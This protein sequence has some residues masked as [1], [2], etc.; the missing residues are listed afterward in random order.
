[1]AHKRS[2]KKTPFGKRTAPHKAFLKKGRNTRKDEDEKPK[3]SFGRPSGPGNRR[4]KPEDDRFSK[5]DTPR[6]SSPDERPKKS[7]IKRSRPAEGE[8]KPFKRSEFTK[9]ST[10][11]RS[12]DKPFSREKRES[13]RGDFK[14]KS[15]RALGFVKK[16]KAVSKSAPSYENIRKEK[17][18]SDGLTRLNKYIANSGMGS[19]REA[20]EMI[21][22][23]LISVNGVTITEMG[24]KVKQ[25]DVVRYEDRVLKAEKLV[26]VLLNKPKG[27]ITTT[28]DPK[29]RKTIMNLVANACKERL[30]PVGRLDR[31]TTGLL[32]LTNDGELADKL[33]HP[34]YNT[35]KIYKVELDRPLTKNDFQKIQEGVR[36]E[37]G[38]AIVDD[39]AIVSDDKKSIGIELHIGWNR[40]VRRIFESLEYEVVK[41]DRVIFAGL[42]KKD[43]PR[44]EWRFLKPEEVVKLKH[45]K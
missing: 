19:R 18:G 44:G 9:R 1:M 16:G 37:E 29:E 31:N 14:P 12:A 17:P 32:L 3:R 41:L 13:D 30:Y 42:D 7:F 15:G 38:K 23:G 39:L 33:T 36:L 25:G 43:L 24:H 35:K 6:S 40:I 2:D 27:F 20:D 26:Y 5:R 21:K 8:E 10:D 45:F 28:S 34:S 4:V 11:K 22:K